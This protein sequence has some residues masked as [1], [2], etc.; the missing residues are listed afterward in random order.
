MTAQDR[1]RLSLVLLIAALTIVVGLIINVLSD[2]FEA[3]CQAKLGPG[4]WKYLLGGLAVC[5]VGLT[6]LTLDPGKWLGGGPAKTADPQKA[7]ALQNTQNQTVRDWLRKRYRTRLDQKMAGRLPIN[8]RLFDNLEGLAGGRAQP[9]REVAFADMGNEIYRAFQPAR[10]RLLVVGAPGSGKT[11]QL[12]ELA[13]ELL[14]PE[15]PD[16]LPAVLNLATWTSEFRTLEDWLKKI[17]PT[18]LGANTTLAMK[19]LA[20]HRVVL[21]LDGFDEMAEGQRLAC[22]EAIGRYGSER[23]RAEFVISS[24]KNEYLEVAAQRTPPVERVIEVGALSD[25]QIEAELIRLDREAEKGSRAFLSAFRENPTI[26]EVVQ[27]PFYFNCLQILFSRGKALPDLNLRTRRLKALETDILD[28]FIGEELDACSE[29][30]RVRH[31]LSFLA[32]RMEARG[33]VL[34]ELRDLQYDWWGK[35]TYKHI[36]LLMLITGLVVTLF[37]GICFSLVFGLSLG[38]FSKPMLGLL[39][40]MGSGLSFGIAGIIMFWRA[41]ILPEI[42]TTEAVSWSIRNFINFYRENIYLTLFGI[43]LGITIGGLANGIVSGLTT[44]LG[45]GLLLGLFDLLI[46]KH[47]ALL[48]ITHPY[49]RFTASLRALHFSILQHLLL[50]YQLAR[51][52]LLPLRLVDFLNEMAPSSPQKGNP[53]KRR[54][55][56]GQ[57][58]LMETDGASWRFRHRLVQEWF[59]SR[60]DNNPTG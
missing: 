36:L 52:G 9:F 1:K 49:Q 32:S 19:L 13:C 35:W 51:K 31:W 41:K 59:A 42:V 11:T 5:A 34:F 55:T 28:R 27:T 4:Y 37:F 12:L 45:L 54:F 53:R 15:H 21:L 40:G 47:S 46:V 17:L 3:F 20:E 60:L 26:R 44:G 7:A 14:K 6:A 2:D 30:E 39:I 56:T 43:M 23:A 29:P 58:Y 16:A 48:Q 22:F 8:L 24:R 33:K 25:A 18:E 38:L 50:R 10:G 57:V